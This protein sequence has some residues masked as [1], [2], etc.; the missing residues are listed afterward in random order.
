[1]SYLQRAEWFWVQFFEFLT[2]LFLI[3]PQLRIARFDT[4]ALFLFLPQLSKYDR[5][6]GV[7][8]SRYFINKILRFLYTKYFVSQI[9]ESSIR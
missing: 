8:M 4:R 3:P 9:V 6:Y 5:I 7:L 1:M 2:L